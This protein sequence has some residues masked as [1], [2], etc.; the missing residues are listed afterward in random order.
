MKTILVPVDLSPVTARVCRMA[1]ELA[2]T[3]KGRVVLLHVVQPPPVIMSDA[4]AFDA[5]QL[6]SL[7]AVAEKVAARKLA[8]FGRACGKRAGEVEVVQ[9]TGQPVAVILDRAAALK[10]DYI[11]LGSHGHGAVYDLL[12]GSTSQGVLRKARCPVLVVPAEAGKRRGK[13]R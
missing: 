5:G 3:V 13:A 9:R 1:C 6:A 7:L 11:V 10:A 8:A 4:Y 2:A 12:M